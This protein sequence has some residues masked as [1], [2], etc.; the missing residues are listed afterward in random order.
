MKINRDN[1]E[2]FM[3]DY[4]DGKLSQSQVDELMLFLDENPDIKDEVDGLEAV[5]PSEAEEPA[6]FQDKAALKHVDA[7]SGNISRDNCETWFI[8]AVEG[9][10]THD[11]LLALD[12]FLNENPELKRDFDLF[13]ATRLEADMSVEFA[14]KNSLKQQDTDTGNDITTENF[15]NWCIAAVEGTLTAEQKQQL[16]A[17]IQQNP[18]CKRDYELFMATKLQADNTIVFEHKASLKQLAIVPVNGIDATNYEQMMVARIEGD[19]TT[20]EAFAFNEFMKQNPGLNQEYQWM[21]KSRLRAENEVEFAGKRQLKKFSIG[22]NRKTV[23]SFSAAAAA[24]ALMFAFSWNSLFPPQQIDTGLASLSRE[25]FS[26]DRKP[27]DVDEIE[28]SYV[29]GHHSSSKRASRGSASK[30]NTVKRVDVSDM[31]MLASA[32]Q[33][34]IKISNDPELTPDYRIYIRDLYDLGNKYQ[35]YEEQMMMAIDDNSEAPGL[36]DLAWN[37]FEEWT[38]VKKENDFDNERKNIFWTAVDLGVNGFNRL[39][40]SNLELQRKVDEQG[41]LDGYKVK[42]KRFEVTRSR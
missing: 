42:S 5:L 4:L 22:F 41:E 27:V 1:Y 20:T 28:T 2:I 11:E 18:G 25:E 17:W 9:T 38:G 7:E 19:L 3:I 6:V 12:D 13:M 36:Q 31:N 30:V 14:D 15:D 24:I 39:T 32:K 29:D 21:R 23:Y 10:L 37:Q 16:E 26:L 34:T 8:A 33:K 35:P 40:G